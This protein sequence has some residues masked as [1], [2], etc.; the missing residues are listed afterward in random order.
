V[1]DA[2]IAEGAG[3]GLN[4]SILEKDIHVTEALHAL[5]TIEFEH[6]VWYFVAAP[7]L[8]KHMALLNACRKTSMSK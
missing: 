3:A 7:A 8:P 5:F 2:V 1:I 4:E 6:I